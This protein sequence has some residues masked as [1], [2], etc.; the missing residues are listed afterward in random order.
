LANNVFSEVNPLPLAA[1]NAMSRAAAELAQRIPPGIDK[2]GDLL[3]T[4]LLLGRQGALA[5]GDPNVVAQPHI[6]EHTLP[7]GSPT[8]VG[9]GAPQPNLPDNG[10]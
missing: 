10:G 6:V 4:D 8:A 7:E 2:G 3:T 5:A 1:P 9:T